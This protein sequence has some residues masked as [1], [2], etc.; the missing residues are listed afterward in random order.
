MNGVLDDQ[1]MQG[2]YF[3][4][5]QG[6]SDGQVVQQG[7]RPCV[8]CLL[9]ALNQTPQNS[10]EFKHEA[11][12]HPRIAPEPSQLSGCVPATGNLLLY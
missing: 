6:S 8:K 1:L 9:L 10:I 5:V 4:A 7:V 12:S 3:N 2:M 11:G